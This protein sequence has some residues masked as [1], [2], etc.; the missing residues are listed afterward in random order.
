MFP[1]RFIR[2]DVDSVAGAS[3]NHGADQR[4]PSAV[5]VIADVE[6]LAATPTDAPA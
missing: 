5:E 6:A 4:Y 1:A 3:V 2:N